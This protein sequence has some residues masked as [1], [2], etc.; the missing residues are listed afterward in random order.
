MKRITRIAVL[1]AFS[2]IGVADSLPALAAGIGKE[3]YVSP[4]IAPIS[5]RLIVKLRPNYLPKGLSV[6]QLSAELGRPFGAGTVAQIKAA[7]GVNLT[8]MHALSSGAHVLSITGKPG[9]QAIDQAI[10]GIARLPDVEYVEEDRILTAKT[11]PND[12]YYTTGPSGNPGL[13]SMWSVSPVASPAPGGTGSY[14]ADFVT[15]WNTTTG[16]GVVVAVVD[17]GVTPHV[18]IVGS[19][20]TVSPATGN[21]VSPGYDFTTE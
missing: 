5:D 12:T 19:G 20:G 6:A 11:A 18:D 15:A 8:E 16:T 2:V 9:R 4:N 1:L 7:A 14:G 13:W 3:D 17:T 10:A 21:L